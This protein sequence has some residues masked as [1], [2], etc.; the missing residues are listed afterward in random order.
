MENWI[1]DECNGTT[2]TNPENEFGEHVCDNCEQNRAER[3]WERFCS[4]FH[5]GGN[6][7]FLSIRERQE[8]ARRLK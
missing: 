6:T 8:A 5:D 7:S 4:D 1:C 3:A 2:T